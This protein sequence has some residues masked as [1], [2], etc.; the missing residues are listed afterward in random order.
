MKI[1]E[2][3]IKIFNKILFKFRIKAF[4][5]IANTFVFFKQMITVNARELVFFPMF[6]NFFQLSRIMLLTNPLYWN[7]IGMVYLQMKIS[8]KKMINIWKKKI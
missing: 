6:I 8:Q 7:S 5:S 1:N 4:Q 2:K 3:Y